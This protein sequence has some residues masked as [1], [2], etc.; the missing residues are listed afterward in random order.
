MLHLHCCRE[1][2]IIIIKILLRVIIRGAKYGRL[3]WETGRPPKVRDI[4]FSV[5]NQQTKELYSNLVRQVQL[6]QF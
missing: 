1:C 6:G 2:L 4:K 3:A 5:V